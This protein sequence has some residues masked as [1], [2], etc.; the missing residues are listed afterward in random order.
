VA[1]WN[2]LAPDARFKAG[3]RVV[4]YTPAKPAKAAGKTV[5]SAKAAPKGTKAMV[6]TVTAQPTAAKRGARVKPTT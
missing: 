6:R 4:V 1:R 2:D 5:K 3:Q